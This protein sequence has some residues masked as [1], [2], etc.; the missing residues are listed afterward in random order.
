MHAFSEQDSIIVGLQS[1]EPHASMRLARG[2]MFY[3]QARFDEAEREFHDVVDLLRPTASSTLVW[4]LGWHG[5]VL[6]ELGRAGEAIA[7]FSELVALAETL[8]ER[9][10]ARGAV[11]AQLAIGYGRLGEREH[12]AECYAKL[13]PFKGQITPLLVD[14][15]LGVAAVAR[16]DEPAAREHFA[17]AE[18]RARTAGMLP[19]LAATLLVRGVFERDTAS[20]VAARTGAIDDSVA[21]GLRL[22]KELG[23]LEFGRRMLARPPVG[24]MPSARHRHRIAGLSDRELDVLRL[25]A[26]GRTNRE[27]AAALFLSQNTVARH[28]TNIFNKTGVENRAGATAFALRHGLA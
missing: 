6:T 21:E 7:R 20:P 26:Q 28:L 12:A 10:R 25:V 14:R 5:L 2:I 15:G 11:F 3:L 23:I 22:C 16:G 27:I 13:L 4:H 18:R 17:D 24:S 19:E 1:P 8:D 9:A